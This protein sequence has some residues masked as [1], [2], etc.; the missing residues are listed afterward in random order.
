MDDSTLTVSDIEALMPAGLSQADSLALAQAIVEGWV[1]DR[2]FETYLQADPAEQQRID[3]MVEDYR[4]RLRMEA[5]RS[6]MR[7]L[8]EPPVKA[9]SVR[10]YYDRHKADLIC[11][12]PL[13]KGLLLK[14][15]SNS[16]AL[17]RLRQWS[18]S[19]AASDLGMIEKE[20]GSADFIYEYFGDTWVEFDIIASE[21]PYGFGNADTFLKS[22]K[23]FETES[24]GYVYLLHIYDQ[25]PS[26]SLMP[27]EFAEMQIRDILQESRLEAYRRGLIRALREKAVR[28]GRLKLPSS[29]GARNIKKE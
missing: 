18:K 25:I 1:E 8:H 4:R 13:A 28:D 12:H 20:T 7:Q 23:F 3:R 26:G 21:I 29:A 27:Y 9:D 22:N 11:E 17:P 14:V 24:G 19:A 15:P 10:A 6:R 16:P 5:Y 2:L